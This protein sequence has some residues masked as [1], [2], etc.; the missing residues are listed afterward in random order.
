MGISR[1]HV[2]AVV[3]TLSC[4]AAGVLW[5]ATRT[6]AQ[7]PAPAAR[8]VVVQA[9]YVTGTGRNEAVTMRVDT[10][11][12]RTW[13]LEWDRETGALKWVATVG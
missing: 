13:T 11:T 8:F 1:A 3:L 7:A 5:L 10:Q 12:G 6:E 9:S 2:Y 4:L